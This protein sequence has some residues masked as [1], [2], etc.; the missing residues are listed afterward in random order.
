[1]IGNLCQEATQ[2]VHLQSTMVNPENP[3]AMVNGSLAKVGDVVEGFRL[4][5][6][7]ARRIYVEREGIT[8]SVPLQ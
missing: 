6:I 4:I 1:M 3:K 5:R 7:E 2:K 8:L